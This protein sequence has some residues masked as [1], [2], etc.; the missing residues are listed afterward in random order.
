[1]VVLCTHL[2]RPTVHF[3]SIPNASILLHCVL[4]MLFANKN[5]KE[6][7]NVADVL[8]SVYQALLYN[9]SDCDFIRKNEGK[10]LCQIHSP[11]LCSNLIAEKLAKY[12]YKTLVNGW[13]IMVAYVFVAKRF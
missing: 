9:E 1:M 4:T 2:H 13:E 6:C 8:T 3:S 5:F 10:T 7:V 12:L 11:P